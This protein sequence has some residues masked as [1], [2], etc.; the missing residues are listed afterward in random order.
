MLLIIIAVGVALFFIL[1]IGFKV[2]GFI[3][4]VL[5]VVVVGFVE[6]MDV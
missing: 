3:V 2:N 5:V 6:G 1:M 4:F